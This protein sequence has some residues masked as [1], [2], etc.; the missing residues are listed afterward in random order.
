M[1]YPGYHADGSEGIGSFL[2][3]SKTQRGLTKAVGADQAA[4]VREILQNTKSGPGKQIYDF[5]QM[6]KEIKENLN[7]KLEETGDLNK[8]MIFI[9]LENLMNEAMPIIQEANDKIMKIK[10]EQLSVNTSSLEKDDKLNED[11]GDSEP[12]KTENGD[13][14]VT[15]TLGYQTTP[16]SQETGSGLFMTR[17]PNAP[18]AAPVQMQSTNSCAPNAHAMFTPMPVHNYCVV[19]ANAHGFGGA[20][21]PFSSAACGPWQ[22]A[23]CGAPE[24]DCAQ[25]QVCYVMAR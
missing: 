14:N 9:A 20:Q 23:L 11:L 2:R 10:A 8:K 19:H 6:L 17:V 16:T 24:G 22:S 7:M 15:G 3:W 5:K 4:T 21:E 1:A 18:W 25:P 12:E 13:T